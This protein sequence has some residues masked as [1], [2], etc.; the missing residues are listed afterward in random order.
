MVNPTGTTTI[1]LH[2][3]YDTE[4]LDYISDNNFKNYDESLDGVKEL[5]EDDILERDCLI[6]VNNET[7]YYIWTRTFEEIF[8]NIIPFYGTW[9]P[10][11]TTNWKSDIEE[12]AEDNLG[13]TDWEHGGSGE[14]TYPENH[15]FDILT[16]LTGISGIGG[17]RSQN[18]NLLAW[19]SPSAGT[20][21]LKWARVVILHELIHNFGIGDAKTHVWNGISCQ[22]NKPHINKDSPDFDE[23]YIM[24]GIENGLDEGVQLQIDYWQEDDL[25]PVHIIT[26][27]YFDDDFFGGL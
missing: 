27:Q 21:N 13:I 8:V 14:V 18:V 12:A 22:C 9:N 17:R 24:S 25:W 19:N 23:G 20:Y 10:S 5:H 11:S 26:L 3:M 4:F 16:G 7:G 6:N 1:F 15:G 2:L